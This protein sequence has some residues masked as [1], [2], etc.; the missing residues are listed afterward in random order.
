ME[1]E[2]YLYN[3][4][5]CSDTTIGTEGDYLLTDLLK[6]YAEQAL[7]IANVSG[8]YSTVDIDKAKESGNKMDEMG[9]IFRKTKD[10]R[11]CYYSELSYFETNDL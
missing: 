6:E 4:G 1:P 10:G 5:I 2:D 8:S 11:Q 9:K 7:H 3:K